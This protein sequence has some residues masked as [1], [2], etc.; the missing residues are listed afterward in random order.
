MVILAVLATL[1]VALALSTQLTDAG[2]DSQ[3]L[4]DFT[5]S[6]EENYLVA[7]SAFEMGLEVLRSDDNDSDGPGDTWAVGELDVEWEG[8]KVALRIVDEE[9]RFPLGRL[10]AAPD[11]EKPLAE[12]LV[13][14][15]RKAGLANA[16][17]AVDALLDWTDSDMIRR[18]SGAE[19]GDYGRNPVKDSPLDS[20][21]E[22]DS[23]P[24]WS[25]P[26]ALALPPRRAAPTLEDLQGQEPGGELALPT[27][28][29][30]TVG[31]G[32]PST[33]SDWLT[34]HS[35][36]KVNVNTAPAE[37]LMSLDPEVTEVTVQEILSRR[38]DEAFRSGE[39]LRQVPGVDAD[40]LFRLEKLVG[41]RSNT[42]EIRATVDEPPGRIVLR[43]IVRRGGGPMKVLWWEV[44]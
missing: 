7:R 25:R 31:A 30:Q 26:P 27:P 16:E 28:E 37:V 17:E 15:A 11:K 18:P 36:G 35:S 41:Y 12:A 33:W 32:E 10:Q 14:F 8:R 20:V 34:L 3:R 2:L 24:A 21:A 40:V 38:Q 1:L 42:F 43:G 44:R 22:L 39:D 19:F 4:A 9:S 13:R 6:R 23:L 5:L 29:T